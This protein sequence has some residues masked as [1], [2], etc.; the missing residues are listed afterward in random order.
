MDQVFVKNQETSF[1]AHVLDFLGFL[2]LFERFFK[3][4]NPSLDLFPWLSIFMQK[5]RKKNG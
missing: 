4:W 3:T 1:S 2:N 5:I